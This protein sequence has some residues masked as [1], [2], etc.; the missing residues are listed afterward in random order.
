[1]TFWS[2]QAASRTLEELVIE[3]VA[4]TG[5]LFGGSLSIAQS[6]SG[7]DFLVVGARESYLSCERCGQVYVFD[8][9]ALVAL[10]G[11][12]D[13]SQAI[14]TFVPETTNVI[15]Q[16]LGTYVAMYD[17]NGDG[18][19]DFILSAPGEPATAPSFRGSVYIHFGTAS[20][21][22]GVTNVSTAD[23]ILRGAPGSLFGTTFTAGDIDRDNKTDVLVVD[24][25][26]GAYLFLGANLHPGDNA[27]VGAANYFTEAGPAG[28]CKYGDSLVMANVNNDVWGDDVL[29]GNHRHTNGALTF[30]GGV[31]IHLSSPCLAWEAFSC[32]TGCD[33]GVNST[34][35]LDACGVCGGDN[36]TCWATPPSN[37][38]LIASVI[39]RKSFTINELVARV[40]AT[41]PDANDVV[42]IVLDATKTTCPVVLVN[43][44]E[45]RLAHPVDPAAL[46]A[47]CTVAVVASDRHT[48]LPNTITAYVV[49]AVYQAPPFDIDFRLPFPLAEGGYP[50]H[51]EVGEVAAMLELSAGSTAPGLALVAGNCS[52]I[53]LDGMNV[54]VS[55]PF[56]FESLGASWCELILANGKDIDD[57]RNA[58]LV[59][60]LIDINEPPTAVLANGT[61]PSVPFGRY[62]M[63]VAP[64]TVIAVLSVVGDPDTGESASFAITSTSPPGA[65]VTIVEG[66]TL[67][68]TGILFGPTTNVTVR[69]SDSGTPTNML[70]LELVLGVTVTNRPPTA[71]LLDGAASSVLVGPVSE[72][73]AVGTVIG[74]L[75]AVGDPDVGAAATFAVTAVAP[76]GAG[77]GLDAA[78]GTQLVVMAALDFESQPLVAVT[79]AARD[80]GVPALTIEATFSIQISNANEAGSA[81]VVAG[82]SDGSAR[83]T[84]SATV[85]DV[86]AVLAVVGDPDPPPGGYLFSEPLPGTNGCPSGSNGTAGAD[87]VF[88]VEMGPSG[89]QIVV[90]REL[91]TAGAV[92]VVAVLAEEADDAAVAVCGE[93]MVAV[94]AGAGAD[95]AAPATQI[96]RTRKV[97]LG[98]YVAVSMVVYAGVLVVLTT[99]VAVA[100]K[101][102]LSRTQWTRWGG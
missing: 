14:A 98:D 85:G 68:T 10:G 13:T 94:A 2:E 36:S 58:S 44:D 81:I 78:T 8:L 16:N 72:L 22:S 67:V 49:M 41:D 9:D 63:N 5:S 45:L 86:V 57:A 46:G 64:G 99:V 90:A 6:T 24:P 40:S 26:D 56:D 50:E 11:T 80:N 38:S 12:H 37:V 65:A 34:A 101:M 28:A 88:A 52:G 77:I 71:I 73:A 70:L 47:S 79:V 102:T 30:S 7:S 15:N 43:G 84:A 19:P 59:L 1:M 25:C 3:A 92:F 97:F 17:V 69:A 53:V 55:V 96:E 93:V 62:M 60:P 29:I 35:A 39:L 95:E 91:P 20:P 76:M 54:T 83:T 51:A 4:E 61:A 87:P 89:G 42:S 27:A 66:A 18:E 31:A 100:R 74:S 75:V 21:P 48:P 23:I 32:L 82:S 33:A